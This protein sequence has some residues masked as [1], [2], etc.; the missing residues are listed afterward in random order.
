MCLKNC[1]VIRDFKGVRIPLPFK[2]PFNLTKNKIDMRQKKQ[3]KI[4]FNSI[5]IG[6]PHRHRNAKDRQNDVYTSF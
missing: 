6:N 4:K 1:L 2:G 3:E 5:R